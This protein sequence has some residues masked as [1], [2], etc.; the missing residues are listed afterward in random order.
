[1]IDYKKYL[2]RFGFPLKKTPDHNIKN[3]FEKKGFYF[4]SLKENLT[5]V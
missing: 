3:F 1:M 4:Q 5:Y 2:D